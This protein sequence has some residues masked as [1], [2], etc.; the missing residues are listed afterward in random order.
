MDRNLQDVMSCTCLRVR[1]AARQLTQIYDHALKPV[2]LSVAQFGLLAN[3]SGA[4]SRRPDGLSIGALAERLGM[5]PTTLNRN[6]K[7]LKAKGL[8][9]DRSDPSD[10]RVRIIQITEKGQRELPPAISLW[11]QAH[12]KVEQALGRKERTA[13]NETL[14]YAMARLESLRDD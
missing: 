13:L 11:R 3:L 5:D 6:L 7:P 9:K 1:R 2:G 14:D 12:G 10:A 4:A 8:V